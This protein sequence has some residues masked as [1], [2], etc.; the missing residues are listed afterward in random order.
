MRNKPVSIIIALIFIGSTSAVSQKVIKTSGEAQIKIENNQSYNDAKN[1]VR[2]LAKIN[3]IE[4]V[5][6]TYIE[7]ETNIDVEDGNTTFKIIGNTKVKGEWLETTKEEYGENLKEL[8]N[9]NGSGIITER[10]ITCKIQGRV[11]EILRPKPAFEAVTLNCPQSVCRTTSY[12]NGEQF[13]ISF[14]APSDGYLSVYI[15]ESENIFRLLPYAE[16]DDNYLDAVP[17]KA[18]KEYIYF[19][20]AEK[21]DYFSDF[22]VMRVDEL[23]MTSKLDR[24]Y[25]QLYVIFSTEPFSKPLLKDGEVIQNA[26]LPKSLTQNQF[27]KWFSDNRIYNAAF[28]YEIINL[29]VIK[30]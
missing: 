1:M 16:M 28:S 24:E 14:K 8:K 22:S 4:N 2:E 27:E 6:G 11:R 3:A 25:S 5:F 7:Q 29:E 18:D 13:Y 19:S 20:Q 26:I 10:W 21:H 12:L 30:K 17:I 23:I 9:P 15:I